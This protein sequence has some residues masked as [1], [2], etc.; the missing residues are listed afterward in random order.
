VPAD[1]VQEE[2]QGVRGGI[3]RVL[4]EG[5]RLHEPVHLAQLQRAKRL[6]AVQQ[7]GHRPPSGVF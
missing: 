7:R 5:E 4:A 3:D 1:L 2:L 6:A